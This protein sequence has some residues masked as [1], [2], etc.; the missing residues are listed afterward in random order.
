MSGTGDSVLFSRISGGVDPPNLYGRR[1]LKLPDMAASD[2]YTAYHL[3]TV[4]SQDEGLGTG[5]HSQAMPPP[6]GPSLTSARAA[7]HQHW[8][9]SEGTTVATP[10][11]SQDVFGSRLPTQ[12]V[13]P[14][15]WANWHA[16]YE[17]GSWSD[18]PAARGNPAEPLAF[19]NIDEVRSLKGQ[20]MPNSAL[21]SSLLKRLDALETR[22]HEEAHTSK[23]QYDTQ[24]QWLNELQQQL[25]RIYA[26]LTH[27][28]PDLRHTEEQKLQL[29]RTDALLANTGHGE[30]TIFEVGGQ[31]RVD[32]TSPDHAIG[33][34]PHTTVQANTDRT[35]KN[36]DAKKHCCTV[37]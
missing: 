15:P 16:Q 28:T 12:A 8:P 4:T 29:A 2:A 26:L 14:S 10:Y 17:N 23:I 20:A 7:T 22:C 5:Q 21:A 11:Q 37:S 30:V 3:A 24:H 1:T 19:R 31:A 9:F 36:R 35:T 25:D 33:S 34:G 13:Q 27:T 32:V 18:I 6:F